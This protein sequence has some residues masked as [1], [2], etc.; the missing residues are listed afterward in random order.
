MSFEIDLLDLALPEPDPM[1]KEKVMARCASA[2]TAYENW[3]PAV[4][5][6]SVSAPDTVAVP[7]G[8]ELQEAI[9][10]NLEM[11]PEAIENL[12][13]IVKAVEAMGAKHGFPL[14]M[15]TS[16]TSKKQDWVES[17]CLESSDPGVVLNQLANIVGF[18]GFSPY[19][20]SPSLLIREMLETAPV[21]H[22]FNEM[23]VTQEFRLFADKGKVL[24]YQPYW[25]AESIQNPSVQDWEP[26]LKKISRLGEKDLDHLVA[27]AANVTKELEGEWSVDFLKDRHGK[28]W[29]IDMAEGALSYRNEKEYTKLAEP[30]QS[31]SFG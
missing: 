13:A 6:A 3:A 29:L 8:F 11:P 9:L 25:P 16:F 22:A 4:A 20:V 31:P 27:M 15:K 23:P 18:Q 7:M 14:F 28:W 24:G 5:K 12:H 26:K 10:E 19:V 17:C 1:I 30:D 21:F 2:P